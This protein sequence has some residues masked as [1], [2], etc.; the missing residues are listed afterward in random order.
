[1]TPIRRQAGNIRQVF[2]ASGRAFLIKHQGW[3]FDNEIDWVMRIGRRI[4]VPEAARRLKGC[5]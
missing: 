4:L 5:E 3:I 1:M 2:T